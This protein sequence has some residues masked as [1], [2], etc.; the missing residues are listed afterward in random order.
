MFDIKGANLAARR[1]ATEIFWALEDVT[2]FIGETELVHKNLA[3]DLPLRKVTIEE[4]EKAYKAVTEFAKNCNDNIT[5]EDTARMQIHCG[6]VAR[7]HLQQT[8]DIF[9][10]ESHVLRLGDVAFATNPFEL[11]L[12]YGNQIRARSKASQTFLI[13][14]ACGVWGYLPT[15]KAEKG[16]HYSAFVG[17]GF[18]G[19][20]GGNLLVRKTIQ[21]INGMFKD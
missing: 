3:I 13:Q 14:L 21:E 5:Y 2:E 10:I 4:Y 9:T 18:A 11:F 19:H 17:S 7:Y 12:N 6:T 8:V 20:E 15:E 1:V 16:S